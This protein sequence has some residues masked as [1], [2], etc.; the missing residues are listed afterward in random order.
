MIK[1]FLTSL[2]DFF[3]IRVLSPITA[4]IDG[5]YDMAVAREYRHALRQSKNPFNV[6]GT[7][8]FS[9]SDED[10]LTL[11]IVKRVGMEKGC[12]A[13]FGAE[14]F[15]NN[16]LVLLAAGWSGFWVG[17]AALPFQIPEASKRLAHT[18]EWVTKD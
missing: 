10:G 17:G 16:T 11:E 18:R 7:K 14:G 6:Y 8:V 9:Q 2:R 4:P 13:E 1:S 5:L 12:F 3:F 15:E